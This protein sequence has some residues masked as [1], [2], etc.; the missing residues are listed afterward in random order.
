MLKRIVLIALLALQTVAVTSVASADLPWPQCY[1]CPG[2]P[3]G[4]PPAR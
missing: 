2:L 4:L 3:G 1:P